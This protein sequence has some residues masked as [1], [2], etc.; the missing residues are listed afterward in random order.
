MNV[1]E[2]CIEKVEINLKTVIEDAQKKNEE[3]SKM[4]CPLSRAMC[5][6]DCVCYIKATVH[7]VQSANPYSTGGY[8][9]A[10]T[11]NGPV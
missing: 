7:A 6:V 5:R 2:E 10:Y 3:R 1:I 9:T 4:F 11:L 8:C